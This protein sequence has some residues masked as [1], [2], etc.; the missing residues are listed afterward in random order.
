MYGPNYHFTAHLDQQVACML[1]TENFLVTGTCGEISGWD[2]TTI[3]SSKIS[4]SKVSWTIQIPA[5]KYVE[6]G[7]A[8][9]NR[10]RVA[11]ITL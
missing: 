3:T 8:N 4:K 9:K 6:T 2:W 5:N 11:P 1:S 10:I 7:K